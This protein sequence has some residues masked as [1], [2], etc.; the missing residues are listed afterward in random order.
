MIIKQ[1]NHIKL[2]KII[3]QK[4]LDLITDA[5]SYVAKLK[6]EAQEILC[7][8]NADAESIKQTAYLDTINEL[9]LAN[10]ILI[11]DFKK[12]VEI[13][14]TNMQETVLFITSRVISKFGK[15][16]LNQMA[17]ARLIG[18]E[19]SKLKDI[20]RVITVKANQN[21]LNILKDQLDALGLAEMIF[22]EDK[23]LSDD[24]CTCST[25]LWTMKLNINKTLEA[26][27]NSGYISKE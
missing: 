6:Q 19:F 15:S 4:D 23:S 12:N 20:D 2:D 9:M 26:I 8:A 13:W 1:L 14:L 21:T 11:D 17:L 22:Q 18:D 5:D 16:N 25:S 27:K 7:R 10:G 3:K 24:E